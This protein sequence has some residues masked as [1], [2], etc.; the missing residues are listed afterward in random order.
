MN[1]IKLDND[2]H[3]LQLKNFDLQI[4]T[5]LDA[6]Q[7]R[8]KTRLLFFA[9]EWFLNTTVGINFFRD[10]LVK[11]YD[12]RTIRTVYQSEVLSIPGVE[13]IQRFVLSVDKKARRLDI[14]MNIKTIYGE[15]AVSI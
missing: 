1:D 4:C 7:Q 5:G 11:K 9:G 12:I 6:L 8:I 10:I 15:T 2:S 3:D 13:S 14:E